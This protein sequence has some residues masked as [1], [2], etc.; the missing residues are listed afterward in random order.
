MPI[1]TVSSRT[2]YPNVIHADPGEC[3]GDTLVRHLAAGGDARGLII[4]EHG[5]KPRKRRNRR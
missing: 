4:V 2:T 5:F 3:A 1:E